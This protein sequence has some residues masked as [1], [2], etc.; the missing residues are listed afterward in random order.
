MAQFIVLILLVVLAKMLINYLKPFLKN[1]QS[2]KNGD[3]IDISEKW[4]N[5]DEMPYR[6][7]NRLMNKQEFQIFQM[8]QGILDGSQYSV[9]PHLPL[10]DL[11]R[12]PADTP[13]R[14]EYLYRI[15]ARSLDMVIFESQQLKPV[16]VINLKSQDDG[17][18]QQITDEFTETALNSAGLKSISINL[19]SPP[20]KAQFISDLNGLGFKL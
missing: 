3:F 11:L 12:V 13:N 4:I 18:M 6:K 14:Q 5:A 2:T 10:A 19:T 15:R 17:K 1:S 20:S 8:L 16:L 9:Y 7:N